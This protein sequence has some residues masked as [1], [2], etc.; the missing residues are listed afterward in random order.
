[1]ADQSETHLGDRSSGVPRSLG[2]APLVRHIALVGVA[3]LVT[4]F[5]VAGAGGRLLMRVAAIAGPDRAI[6]RLTESGFRVGEI[7]LG[8]TLE[9]VIFVGLFAGGI[10]AVIYLVTEP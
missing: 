7:T 2:V 5:V 9:L 1:M 10:G 6:G 8:G 3:G 4:G